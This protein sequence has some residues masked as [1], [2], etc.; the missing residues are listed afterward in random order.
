MASPC[1]AWLFSGVGV[2]NVGT[3]A[4]P[5]QG[6]AHVPTLFTLAPLNK[7]SMQGEAMQPAPPSPASTSDV[8]CPVPPLRLRRQRW[9]GG[10]VQ[11]LLIIV[12]NS[13][14]GINSSSTTNNPG[15]LYAALEFDMLGDQEPCTADRGC[16]I[17]SVEIVVLLS[18]LLLTCR[19][20]VL[21][22]PS[23]TV[24]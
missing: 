11:T 18:N 17:V 9:N 8:E 6:E 24:V 12:H 4:S 20:G 14:T 2:K 19:A 5:N 22:S 10:Y 15:G 3:C 16:R 21:Q 1:I 7:H 23:I 13:R